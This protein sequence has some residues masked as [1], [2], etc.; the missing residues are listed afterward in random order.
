MRTV[1]PGLKEKLQSGLDFLVSLL[2]RKRQW[3]ACYTWEFLTRGVHS[4]VRSEVLNSIVKRCAFV[5]MMI[6]DCNQ[7]A[8][9]F[10]RARF[11]ST[12]V[13]LAA[14]KSSSV[15]NSNSARL[16]RTRRS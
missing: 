5:Y 6:Y 7:I 16:Y 9:A 4:T 14:T 10:V 11:P 3:A 2:A 15:A 1:S 8:I 13:I 12:P